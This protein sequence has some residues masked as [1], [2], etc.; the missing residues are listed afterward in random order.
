MTAFIDSTPIPSV[1]D[2]GWGSVLNTALVSLDNRFA[3]SSGVYMPAGTKFFMLGSDRSGIT[4]TATNFFGVS[5]SLTLGRSYLFE[6]FMIVTNS[7]TGT[8]TLGWAGTTVTQFQASALVSLTSVS[9]SSTGLTGVNVRNATTNATITGGNTAATHLIQV[10]GFVRDD[11]TGGA[12]PLQVS[13]ASGTIT[14]KAGSW[15]HFHDVG[16]N[17]GGTGNISLGTIV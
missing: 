13:V 9:G 5:P 10:R 6:Y 1:G 3:H 11:S 2:L 14:P 8:I 7:S 15:F 17:A 4:T 16:A 12:F